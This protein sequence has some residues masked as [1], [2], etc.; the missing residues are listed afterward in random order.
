LEAALDGLLL[1]D[2]KRVKRSVS[3]YDFISTVN[4]ELELFKKKRHYSVEKNTGT[5][6]IHYN[7]N[8][9]GLQLCY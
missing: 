7:K 2:T 5:A 8:F 4:A 3:N 1:T 6:D 9:G